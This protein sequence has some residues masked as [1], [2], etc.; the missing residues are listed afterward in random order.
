M[1]TN[2]WMRNPSLILGL[3]LA[4]FPAL[5][6]T[7]SNNPHIAV[8]VY[9]YVNL[10]TN[11]QKEATENVKR[12]LGQA[13]L[14]VDF[15]LCHTGGTSIGNK[16]CEGVLRP[17]VFNLR[18]FTPKLAEYR[19]QLG[20]AVLAPEGGAYVTIF[21]R[22]E[23]RRARINGLTEGT[24]LGHTIAH[25][26][27]HLLLG[28]NSHSSSGI[29]RPTWRLCDEEWMAK[30]ALLFDS[31][32]ARRMQATLLSRIAP[33]SAATRR[34]SCTSSKKPRRRDRRRPR[35]GRC[36]RPACRPLDPQPQTLA[37]EGPHLRRLSARATAPSR[38]AL[39]NLR[40]VGR[41]SSYA[42]LQPCLLEIHETPKSLS[43]EP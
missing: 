36:L 43:R 8:L 21:F 34:T 40:A 5:S 42:R 11:A 6:R 15:V 38:P 12:I 23:M 24:L 14:T 19:K 28:P 27:G 17:A 32:Q 3:A 4:A 13:G 20:Y 18:I 35:S 31:S 39:M 37:D 7:S 16:D 33:P 25:E 30:G 26:L 29:M 2:L 41:D 1:K 9:D 22:P 10:S